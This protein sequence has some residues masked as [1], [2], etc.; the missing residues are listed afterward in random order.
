MEQAIRNFNKQFAWKPVMLGSTSKTPKEVEP[1]R[2]TKFV[3]GG[4][5]GSH[6][7]AGLLAG[8]K[9]ELDIVIHRDYGLPELSDATERLFIASSYSGNT[10]ETMDFVQVA[11]KRG[12]AVATIS[13][14]GKLLEFAQKNKLPHIVIPDTK[15]Q[16]RSALGFSMNALA[17]LV[18]GG[19]ILKELSGLVDV[20]KPDELE[21][22][23][24]ALASALRGKVPVVYAST[25]NKAVAYNW[26]IK[27]N[28]TGKIPAFYN[29]FPELNHNEMTGFD[30]IL[31]TEGLSRKFHFVFLTDN[32]DHPQVQRRMQVT[33]KLYE[34]RGL[35]VT[36][37]A[38]DNTPSPTQSRSAPLDKGDTTLE[39]IFSSLLIADWTALHLSKIYGTEA[40]AV[41]MVEEFK[42]LINGNK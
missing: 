1:K 8:S 27:F 7:A 35:P 38:L 4:M 14:G 20:L 24:K 37:V 41:P 11:H 23:G 10:E 25:R 3:V 17:A 26:K 32:A 5:G 18:G 34:A 31:T 21:A 29:V 33:K 9:P 15:I 39:K 12:H 6:L 2:F 28:E 19:K 16:P 42:K 36:E 13:V 22:K 40:E 30:V